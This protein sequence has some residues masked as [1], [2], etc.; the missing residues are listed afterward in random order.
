MLI[1]SLILNNPLSIATIVTILRGF[2]GGQTVPPLYTLFRLSRAYPR[3]FVTPASFP[4]GAHGLGVHRSM[5]I[6]SLLL[7]LF[8]RQEWPLNEIRGQSDKLWV[9]DKQLGRIVVVEVTE[10]WVRGAFW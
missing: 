5:C 7:N 3:W 8:V 4:C 6:V 1:L 10:I 9:K 2:A